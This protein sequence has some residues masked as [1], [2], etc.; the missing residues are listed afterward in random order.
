M[1]Y[2]IKENDFVACLNCGFIDKMHNK[3][4]RNCAKCKS[5]AIG[6]IT[7]D[8]AQAQYKKMIS[9]KYQAITGL[10]NSEE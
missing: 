4:D 1:T 5:Y 3:L 7:E 8:E 6:K 9:Y 2:D 10:N